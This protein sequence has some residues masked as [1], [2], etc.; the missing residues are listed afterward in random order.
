ML[1]MFFA[2]ALVVLGQSFS[3]SRSLSRYPLLILFVHSV[4]AIKLDGAFLHG[5]PAPFRAY[6]RISRHRCLL[7][8][9]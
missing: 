5:A 6:F 7:L 2:F 9:N 3:A 8:L 4:E 1:I